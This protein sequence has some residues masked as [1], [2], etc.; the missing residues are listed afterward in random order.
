MSNFQPRTLFDF[1]SGVGTSL[2]AAKEI[3][4]ELSEVFCVDLS[5]DMTDLAIAIILKGHMQHTLPAGYTFRLHLP[6]DNIITYDLVTCSHALLDIPTELQRANIID[7][8]WRK[9][10]PDGGFLILVENGTN[11]GFQVLQEARHYLLQV[12]KNQSGR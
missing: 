1:G 7:N 11:A 8:L 4:S 9:T 6:R 5:K 3:F 2:W 10:S 12:M